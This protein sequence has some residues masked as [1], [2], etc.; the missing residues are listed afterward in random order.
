MNRPDLEFTSIS[1]G[2]TV[3]CGIVSEQV[4]CWG[5]DEFGQIGNGLDG[6]GATPSQAIVKNERF[7]TVSAGGTHVC[8]LSLAGTAYC[9]GNDA[10]GQ[11]GDHRGRVNSTTPIP[12]GDTTLVFRSISAGAAHTCA[13]TDSGTAY[14]WG[15]NE[16]GQLGTGSQVDSGG[17]ALV[18]GGLTFLSISAGASHTCAVDTASNLHCWGD[19][20]FGQLGVGVVVP[21][22]T[23]PSLVAGGGGYAAVSAGAHHTCGIA[24]GTVR[25]WG[26]SAL[27]EVGDGI[28]AV[29]DVIAPVT[30][31]GLTASSITVGTNHSCAITTAFV[32]MC[33][34]SNLFGALG[35]EY[36]AAFRATPQVVAR[37]R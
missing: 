29:H 24:L 2:G 23:V 34:G 33:W 7:T 3:A 15:N 6:A 28:E 37:P 13:L 22:L 5:S 4:Y 18:L 26:R 27:G 32:S 20:S 10:S 12:V 21:I 35:N 8:A 1:T 31:T 9:W 17:P 11:L 30:V 25:C 16:S 19:N 14:C 36:Q